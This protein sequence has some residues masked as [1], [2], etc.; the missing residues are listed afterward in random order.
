MKAFRSARRVS[1]IILLAAAALVGG[2]VG[3]LLG[4]CGPFTDVTTFC[5]QVL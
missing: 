4:L 5:P 1:A 3:A 2:G